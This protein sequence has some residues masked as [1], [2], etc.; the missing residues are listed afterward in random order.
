MLTP[1]GAKVLDCGLAKEAAARKTRTGAGKWRGTWR[2]SSRRWAGSQ[3]A[4]VGNP[5][6]WNVNLQGDLV[7]RE[8]RRRLG[9]S[10]LAHA[11]GSSRPRTR[12][13]IVA[14]AAL[15]AVAAVGTWA[16]LAASAPNEGAS[17][18]ATIRP[19]EPLKMVVVWW[20][21]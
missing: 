20:T 15:L 12:G 7:A 1:T 2:S 6:A 19:V 11:G 5:P 17:P 16:W 8:A 14:A 10:R 21:P 4:W 13:P 9:P 3:P 18:I